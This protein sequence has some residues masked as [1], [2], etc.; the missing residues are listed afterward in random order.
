MCRIFDRKLGET[1]INHLSLPLLLR[2]KMAKF[3]LAGIL[4]DLK[5]DF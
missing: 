5:D 3:S 1:N 2:A 4:C